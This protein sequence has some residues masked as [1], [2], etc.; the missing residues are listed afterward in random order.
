[1]EKGG[2]SSPSGLTATGNGIYLFQ[3]IIYLYNN[4]KYTELLE[5]LKKPIFSLQDLALYGQKIIPSQLSVMADKGDIIRLKNGLYVI[6]SRKD[7]LAP[8]HIAFRLY[9]P[10]YVSLEWAL[11]K[12]GL[13][14]EIPFNVTSV[15]AKTTRTFTNFFGSFFYKSIKPDLFFG[16]EKREDVLGQ[17]YLLAE[18]EKALLDYL[19]FNLSHI[20]TDTDVEGLRLNPFTIKELDEKKLASYAKIFDSERLD[21]ILLCLHLNK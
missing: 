7:N 1:M 9:E 19:Y 17:P 11:Q 20:K 5:N 18:P 3:Y 2:Y 8:E 4:M 10:S 14:P 12:H 21:H 15:T 6:A 13:M 16:Y